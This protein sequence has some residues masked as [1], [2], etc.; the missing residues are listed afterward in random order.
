MKI[1]TK[2]FLIAAEASMLMTNVVA[3]GDGDGV[4]IDTT[5]AQNQIQNITDA[6]TKIALWAIPMVGGIAILVTIIRWLTLDEQEREQRPVH[7]PIIKILAVVIVA[8]S[9]NVIFRIFGLS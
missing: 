1:G 8:E 6:L 5:E 3:E 9:I 7:K 2:A 4:T